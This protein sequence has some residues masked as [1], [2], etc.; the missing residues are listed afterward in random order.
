MTKH[1]CPSCDC[2]STYV[3]RLDVEY[4]VEAHSVDQATRDALA[5]LEGDSSKAATLMYATDISTEEIT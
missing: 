3:V 5:A 1:D 2:V 4:E